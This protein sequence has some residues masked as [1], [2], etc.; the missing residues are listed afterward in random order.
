VAE[1]PRRGEGGGEGSGLTLERW[2]RGIS[3]E[4]TA[5]DRL[6]AVAALLPGMQDDIYAGRYSA[7]GRP[8]VTSLQHVISESASVLEPYR[9]E[10]N[11]AVRKELG[12]RLG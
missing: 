3:P 8:N 12:K 10:L 1:A 5:E 2:E 6:L 11:L 7:A 4:W 9:Q